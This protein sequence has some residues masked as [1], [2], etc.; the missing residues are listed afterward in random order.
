MKK[1]K[2]L[3]YQFLWRRVIKYSRNM[4]GG[5]YTIKG[6]GDVKSL[7]MLGDDLYILIDGSRPS[8]SVKKKD[9]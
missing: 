6:L 7:D 5:V 8:P 9:P 3:Y 4:D 1:L 2:H